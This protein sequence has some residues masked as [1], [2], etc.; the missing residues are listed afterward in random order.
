V[1]ATG[2]GGTLVE[3]LRTPFDGD[4]S[5]D[6]GGKLSGGLAQVDSDY[7]AALGGFSDEARSC[8]EITRTRA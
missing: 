5:R 7:P 8:A 1:Y 6:K 4:D 2:I 3:K